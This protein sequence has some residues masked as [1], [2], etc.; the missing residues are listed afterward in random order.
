MSWKESLPESLFQKEM[1]ILIGNSSKCGLGQQ[2]K[3]LWEGSVEDKWT[4]YCGTTGSLQE[5]GAILQAV[6]RSLSFVL[7]WELTHHIPE[8]ACLLINQQNK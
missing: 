7:A 2:K 6:E 4:V 3:Y 8:K 5:P 1:E